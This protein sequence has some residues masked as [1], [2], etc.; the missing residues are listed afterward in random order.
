MRRIGRIHP[1]ETPPAAHPNPATM[2]GEKDEMTAPT[3]AGPATGAPGPSAIAD[4]DGRPS[5]C[6]LGGRLNPS[7]IAGNTFNILSAFRRGTPA[8][9]GNRERP[10]QPVRNAGALSDAAHEHISL[11]AAIAPP[12][13]V[14]LTPLGTMPALLQPS[15]RAP[16]FWTQ[17]SAEYVGSRSN[18]SRP[19]AQRFTVPCARR[20][21]RV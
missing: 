16:R 12:A 1:L 20:T 17:P 9:A 18:Q 5:P 19:I 8:A 2:S 13:C 4:E 15:G 14:P 10:I 11:A 7:A 21:S 3:S 6:W